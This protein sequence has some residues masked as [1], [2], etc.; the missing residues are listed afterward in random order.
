MT[1]SIYP[2][3]KEAEDIPV[4]EQEQDRDHNTEI[5]SRTPILKSSTIA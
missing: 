4:R 2:L 3:L 1:S 5:L